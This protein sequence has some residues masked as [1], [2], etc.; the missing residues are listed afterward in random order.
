VKTCCVRKVLLV[1][2]GCGATVK[3]VPQEE[4]AF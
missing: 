4:R 3:S 2:H 1:I